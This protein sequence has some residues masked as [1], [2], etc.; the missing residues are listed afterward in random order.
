MGILSVPSDRIV[1]IPGAPDP[2]FRPP[3]ERAVVEAKARWDL[4]EPYVVHVGYQSPRKNLASLVRALALAKASSL[5]LVLVGREGPS[6]PELKALAQERGLTER[7]RFLGYVEREALPSLYAG[8]ACAVLCSL[9]EGFGLPALE[10]MACGAPVVATRVGSLPEV[11][12]DAALWV[13]PN[14]DAALASAIDQ[15]AR[16]SGLSASLRDK[17]LKRAA[18]FSWER[19][20]RETVE[21]YRSLVR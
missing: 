6:T 12:Q 1:V 9:D 21:I 16:D 14:D 17:G 4:R 2:G 19:T 13:P 10:A 8:A 20:A 15:V 18:E 3:G 11:A 7:I 5:S